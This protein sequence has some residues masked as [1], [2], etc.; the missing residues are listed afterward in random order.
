MSTKCE[1]NL[2][3]ILTYTSLVCHT[4]ILDVYFDFAAHLSAEAWQE[5]HQNVVFSHITMVL[6]NIGQTLLLSTVK[7]KL[8]AFQRQLCS[9]SRNVSSVTKTDFLECFVLLNHFH[10]TESLIVASF[11]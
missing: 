11:T 10:L 3:N 4:A 8:L 1:G 7:V 2:K 9:D 5:M 6:E